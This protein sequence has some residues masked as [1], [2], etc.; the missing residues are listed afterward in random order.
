MKQLVSSMAIAS[1]AFAAALGMSTGVALAQE[2][3]LRVA[4]AG[5]NP[6]KG[7]FEM[8][9]GAQST[10]PLMAFADSLTFL[11]P[12]GS[13]E[14]GLATSWE[15]KNPTTW[16]VKIRPGVMFHNGEPMTVD[17]IVKNVDFLI[18]DEAGQTSISARFLGFAGAKK[19]DEET[20]EITSKVPNP[21]LDRW[22]TLFRIMD[23]DYQKDVGIKGFTI[24]PI[25]TGSFKVT[26][27]TGEKMEA[28]AFR[29]AWRPAKFDKLVFNTLAEPASRVAA[30]LS[31]Q[32]EMAWQLGAD[33]VEQIRAS[34]QQAIVSRIDEILAMKFN[35]IPERTSVDNAP[36]RDVRVRQ[37]LNYGINREA[38]IKNVLGGLTVAASQS[39]T[40]STNGYQPDLKPYPY[41]PEKAKAL[42]AEAGYGDGLDLVAELITIQSD[43]TDTAQFVAADL[44]KIGVNLELRQISLSDILGK[45]RGQKQWN[46]HVWFGLVEPFPTNDIMR[47]FGTD[48]CNF[49]GAFVCD[50]SIQPTIEAANQEFDP[51]KRADLMRDVVKFYHD[52]ALIMYMFERFQID[53]LAANVKN[54]RLFNRAIN[55]HEI[56]LEG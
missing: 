47:P 56:E 15:V 32:V 1:L 21:I 4:Q 53:G 12:D 19:I 31:G 41:D 24:A 27:W 3:T 37:A 49:F 35:T 38:F 28:E 39:G 17:Q 16:V 33:N 51:K 54:Y 45:L 52:E 40:P 42:L 50:E 18:N 46:G 5:F 44:K 8:A 23:A 55:W 22:F 25:G 7:R 2:K 9:F 13:V 34:G 20:V 11:N 30:L 48:S 6:Q 14:P 26:S 29:D 43:Y 36:I 10:L